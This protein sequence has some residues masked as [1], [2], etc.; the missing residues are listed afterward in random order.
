MVAY[1]HQCGSSKVYFYIGVPKL[2][3]K[4]C[5]NWIK[6]FNETAGTTFCTKGSLDKWYKGWA[7]LGLGKA[8]L[9]EAVDA[10]FLELVENELCA[11]QTNLKMARRLSLSESSDSREPMVPKEKS[12]EAKS[13]ERFL[14]G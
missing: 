9:Q 2:T 7:R 8:E 1:L 3:C 12:D 10:E 6:A 5:Y 14:K 13:D 4:P 11:G